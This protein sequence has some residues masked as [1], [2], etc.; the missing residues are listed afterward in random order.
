MKAKELIYNLRT[1][2][3]EADSQL[4]NTTDQH[5][6]YM[7]DEAR[8]KLAAQKMDA[9]V[10]VVQMTQVVD[11]KPIN[12]P[13]DEIGQIGSTKVIKLVI[14]DP[15][16]YLNGSGIFTVGTTD[17]EESYTQISYS[18]L[19]TALSRKYT[20]KSPK[21]FWYENAVYIVNV[22]LSGLQKI[23]VR[24]IFDEPYKVEQVMG[25][26]K[27][28][29]PFDWEYPL[30]MKDADTIYKLAMDSDL[31]WGDAA[32]A[33]INREKSKQK[34]KQQLLGA[35]QDLGKTSE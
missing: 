35:L 21:W 1:N 22:D 30:S 23:R 19:L 24:G 6:M 2:L 9:R 13:K 3:A 4:K 27:Y 17:G 33:S 16:A 14:P 31:G 12:A 8:A 18:Q 5:L 20:A 32:I 26:Y 25:R 28:L 11:V 34:G 15:I 29:K 7:L 10:N